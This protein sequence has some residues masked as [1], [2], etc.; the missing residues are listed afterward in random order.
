MLH[1]LFFHLLTSY[2][3]L[4]AVP[5]L[6]HKYLGMSLP[7]EDNGH[8]STVGTTWAGQGVGNPLQITPNAPYPRDVISID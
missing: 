6:E 3:G 5:S 2:P 1:A 8:S 4:V 7:L